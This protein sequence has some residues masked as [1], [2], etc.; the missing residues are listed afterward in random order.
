MGKVRRMAAEFQGQFQEAMREAE[1]ADLKKSVDEMT[2]SA[3]KS[4]TDFDP[5]GAVRKEVESF[6]ADPLKD[7]STTAPASPQTASPE[8]AVPSTTAPVAANAAVAQPATADASLAPDAP[9]PRT[10]GGA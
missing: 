1:V 7:T 6:T 8:A 9:Q 2:E 4:F 3:T 10:G 5:I